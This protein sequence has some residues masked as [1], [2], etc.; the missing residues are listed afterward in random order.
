MRKMQNLQID[1]ERLIAACLNDPELRI[2]IRDALDGPPAPILTVC[3]F[4][5]DGDQRYAATLKT[6]RELSPGQEGFVRCDGFGFVSCRIDEVVRAEH[7]ASTISA[8]ELAARLGE[9]DETSGR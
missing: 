8:D 7:D 9:P 6:N 5:S 2:R 4:V 3:A 1:I